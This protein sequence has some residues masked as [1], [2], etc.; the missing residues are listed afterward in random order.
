[1]VAEVAGFFRATPH[2]AT[3][4]SLKRSSS[5][6]YSVNGVQGGAAVRI[7]PSRPAF[8]ISYE[9]RSD[10][11]FSTVSIFVSVWKALSRVL[12]ALGRPPT[13]P[14]RIIAPW[15]FT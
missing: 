8:S 2:S 6:V 4:K 9:D 15:Y 11:D 5:R 1:M 10:P 12:M 14:C 3:R 13:K 7:S